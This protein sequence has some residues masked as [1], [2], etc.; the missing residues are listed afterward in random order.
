MNTPP[1][2][3]PFLFGESTIRTII[4]D[5]E[6]WFLASDICAILE[7]GN[8][9]MALKGNPKTG[10]LGLDEDERGI[11]IHDT[12]GGPQEVS[13]VNEPGLYRLIFKSRKTEARAFQRWVF[14][15]VLPSI[16]KRGFYSH[17]TDQLLSFVREL[18]AMGFTPK[19]ASI[20]ARGEFPPITRKEQRIQELEQLNAETTADPEADLFLS[21]MAPAIEYRMKDF[22]SMLPTGHRILSIKTVKGR[23]TAIGMVM[24]RLVRTGKLRRINAR[25]ATFA[26]ASDKIVP[27]ER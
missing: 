13:I 22:F 16:R 18:L 3:T 23:D 15:E 17:R 8:V 24:E 7:L 21:L 14:K 2:I 11:M 12:S 19:D 4:R 1:N 26:L 20:L 5:D 9:S 6:P 27:M 10:N 25:H